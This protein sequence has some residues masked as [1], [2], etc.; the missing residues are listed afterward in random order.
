MTGYGFPSRYKLLKTDEFSSVFS[1][2]R[3]L[4]GEKLALHSMPNTFGYPRIGIVVS[5]KVARRAVAR[6]YMRRAL[7]EWFRHYR[8]QIADLDLVIRVNKPF[9]RNEFNQVQVELVQLLEK[10]KQRYRL[11]Q[12]S[13]SDPDT[14]LAG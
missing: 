7:R 2:R 8:T 4:F 10:L 13:N 1:F 11:R 3:R 5:K 9:G 12:E 14:N 6:N